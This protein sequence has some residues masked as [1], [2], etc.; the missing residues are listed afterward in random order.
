MCFSCTVWPQGF[1]AWI[2]CLF[3]SFGFGQPATSFWQP[4][5]PESPF[6]V[7]FSF[8]DFQMLKLLE[9]GSL[10]KLWDNYYSRRAISDWKL[11]EISKEP[12]VQIMSFPKDHR[13]PLSCVAYFLVLVTC[14]AREPLGSRKWSLVHLIDCFCFSNVQWHY[15]GYCLRTE[16]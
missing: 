15:E 11:G 10:S 14:Q 12:S 4:L 13:Q 2:L 8:F 16:K 1:L 5:L 9:A 7:A 3:I 6:S